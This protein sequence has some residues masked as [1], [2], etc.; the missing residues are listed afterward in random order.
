MNGRVWYRIV[1]G[2]ASSTWGWA[3]CSRS[4]L[5][6]ARS[7]FGAAG[8][9]HRCLFLTPPRRERAPQLSDQPQQRAGDAWLAAPGQGAELVPRAGGGS[10]QH[11]AGPHEEL[12]AGTGPGAGLGGCSGQPPGVLQQPAVISSP[13][14]AEAGAQEAREPWHG[15]ADG[16][17][18]WV[19][20]RVL[21]VG[22]FCCVGFFLFY[23]IFL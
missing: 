22:V 4:H 10:L 12:R 5:G 23:L 13:R 15:N 17:S 14:R 18:P 9:P 3:G 1:R 2:K 16:K 11:G 19:E 7:T 6:A 20:K 8:G 21:V